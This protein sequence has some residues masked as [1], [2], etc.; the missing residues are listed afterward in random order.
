MFKIFKILAYI[1]KTLCFFK[2][3]NI[4]KTVAR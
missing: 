2:H 4:N 1:I 3:I